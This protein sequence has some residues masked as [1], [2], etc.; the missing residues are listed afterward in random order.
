MAYN[1]K[2][3]IRKERRWEKQKSNLIT[4][5]SHDLRTPLTSVIGFLE[6]IKKRNYKNDD[7]LQ[8]YST[9]SLT[10]A[11]ELKG[12]VDQLFEF[13]KISN[14]DITLNKS[15]INLHE[16]IEQVTI[17]FIPAFEEGGM[18]YRILSKNT[19]LTISGDAILLV[20]AYENIVSNAIKYGSEGKYLD[21]SIEKEN[22]MGIVRFINYGD[23]IEE[24]DLNDLF[25]RLYRVEKICDKKEGTG[26]GLAI[27]KAIIESHNG[28]IEIFSDRERTEFKI[29]LPL[30]QSTL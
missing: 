23:M 9:V 5:L 25:K 11:K 30:N 1:I 18:E 10:K 7:Q 15:K 8:H 27:V 6:L 17:G 28:Y 3:L 21:I 26:L 20:R 29:K 13:S 22:S 24:K 4:N 14:G 16:L 12:S 19:G 2:E